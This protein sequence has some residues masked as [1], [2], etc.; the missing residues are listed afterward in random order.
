MRAMFEIAMNKNYAELAK[1][2]LE[3]CKLL[4]KRMQ[5]SDNP[6]RQFSKDSSIDKLTNPN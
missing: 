2:T 1:M 3:W 4:D 5:P 6:L